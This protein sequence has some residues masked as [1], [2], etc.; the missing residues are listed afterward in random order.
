MADARS[1]NYEWFV[2]ERGFWNR[3]S[4]LFV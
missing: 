3:V 1:T 2:V 4:G